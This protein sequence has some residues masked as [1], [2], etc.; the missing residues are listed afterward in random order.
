MAIEFVTTENDFDRILHL[1]ITNVDLVLTLY[2]GVF[3]LY[4]GR[5]YFEIVFLSNIL[6]HYRFFCDY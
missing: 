3:L 4:L 5:K 6:H 2:I 1:S